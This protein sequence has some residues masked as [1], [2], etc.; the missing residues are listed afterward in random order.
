MELRPYQREALDK[1]YEYWMRNRGAHPLLVL[2]T[3]SGKSYVQASLMQE[4]ISWD[5]SARVVSVTHVKELIQQNYEELF[6]VWEF[7]PAG[8]YSAG[9]KQRCD[10]QQ[11]LFCGIQSVHRK[12]RDIGHV[13]ILIIDEGHLIGRN[14]DTMYRRFIDALTAINPR[15]KVIGLT[16]TPFRLDSGRL[17]DGDDRVFDGIAYEVGVAGLMADG[18]L[19]P[20]VSKGTDN[21]IDVTGVHRR[22]GDYKPGELQK[23]ADRD[24]VTRAAIAETLQFFHDRNRHAGLAF[25]TG[26]EHAIHVAEEFRSRGT[27][28]E[29]VSADTPAE[30]RTRLITAFREGR[31][32]WLVSVGVLSTGFNVPHVDIIADLAPTLSTGR[33]IQKLGRGTRP[34]FPPGYDLDLKEDRL[35]AIEASQKRDCLI[36]DFARNIERH[37]PFDD[38]I[39]KEPGKGGGEAPVKICDVCKTFVPIQLH[40]CPHCGAEFE[41][42]EEVKITE[43]AAVMPVMNASKPTWC[44]VS[45][46]HMR[47]HVKH[48]DGLALE[49]VRVEYQCGLNVYSDWIGFGRDGRFGDKADEWWAERGGEFPAPESCM[50]AIERTDELVCP[51]QILLRR[52]GEYWQVKAARDAGSAEKVA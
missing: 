20:L 8:I 43:T 11:V 32:P 29:V 39:V 46:W 7:A 12:A 18:Y 21:V 49:S 4:V 9:L 23:A 3:G 15:L 28:A 19:C 1:T 35:A 51:A 13:D 5:P 16:A 30:E 2:P 25:T 47:L 40:L 37:G 33:Y 27:P 44:D 38:P 31:L 34:V 24:A 45:G 50:E 26:V 10:W 22:G 14:S 52:D 42:R 6:R 17:D 41:I 48:K 36:L